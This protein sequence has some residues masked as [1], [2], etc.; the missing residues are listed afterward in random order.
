MLTPVVVQAQSP[1]ASPGSEFAVTLNFETEQTGKMPRGWGGGPPETISVDS[2]VVHGGRWA[3]RLERSATSP[4]AFSTLT[5]AIPIDF[6]GQ[7]LEWRGFLRTENV[8]EFTGLWM[9]EDGAGGS[10]AF[11]NMQ[12]RQVNGTRGWTEYSITLPLRPAARTLFVG[13]L[14]AGTGTVWADDLQLLVD[15]KPVWDAPKVERPKTAI[16]LDH[17][18][19]AASGIVVSRLSDMQTQNLVTLGKVWGF[20]KYHHPVVTAGKRHWD[21][22]LFRV[23][24]RVLAAGDRDSANA[25]LRDWIRGLGEVPPCSACTT[26]R[27]DDLH[28]SP[29]VGWIDQEAALGSDLTALLRTVYRR[30]TAGPQFYVSLAPNIG[31]PVFENEPA[32]PNVKFPDA[33]YQLLA[34]YRLW[35]VIEYWY[36]NRNV[37]DQE[38]DTVLADFIPR[39]AGAKTK[40]EY[41]LEMLAVIARI[42]DTHANL[43]SAPPQFRPPAGACALPV[44]TRFVE[45]QAVVTGYSDAVA[46]PSTGLKIG[47]VI[48]SLDG[49]PVG[50]LVERWAPYYPASNRPTRLRD[51][52]RGM[53]RGACTTARAGIRRDTQTTTITAQRLSLASLN[54]T[55]GITHDLRG[56]TFRMLSDDVAYLKLSSVKA[57]QVPDYITRAKGT[58]GLVIDIRNYPSEFVVF[59]LGSLLAERATP[60][61]RFTSGDLQNPGAFHWKEP[62]SLTSSAPHYAGKIVILV[63]ETTQSQAEYTTMAFRSVPQSRVVGSTTAG[64][65][66]NV[67][68]ILLPGGHRTMISGLGVFYPD[69]KPTQRV[70][71]IPDVEVRPT[72]AGIHA[73]RDEVLEEAL[74]QILGRDTPRDQIEKLSKP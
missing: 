38:W 69:K 62:L 30:R 2:E 35:N 47:D 67:S 21:Y 64:A 73:G 39:V 48:E 7:T 41:Q 68:E 56:E 31:N 58:K 26:L 1:V 44:I 55:E 23:M 27:T 5:N 33:G 60:F 40:D 53:T 37:L 6:Q 49:V 51:V 57:S 32:Y 14:V 72:I 10:V 46:G 52:A 9:R 50:E 17:D 20:L 59:T 25:A 3:V 66:G 70:G 18:F 61:V 71:I 28:L 22:E 4:Q 43:W 63:D 74:R 34:L 29:D 19:D 16:D 12:R 36:P 45:N 13:V 24:P 54:Q 11:D 15:G 65:D 42:T 8:S